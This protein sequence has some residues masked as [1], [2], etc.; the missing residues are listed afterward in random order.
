MDLG[1]SNI[2]QQSENNLL[3]KM[4]FE[5]KNKKLIDYDDYDDYDMPN[6]ACL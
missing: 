4:I 3:M 5:Q 1:Y 6:H 2:S